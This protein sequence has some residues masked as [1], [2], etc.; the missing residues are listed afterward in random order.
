MDN[1]TTSAALARIRASVAS[2]VVG[3]EQALEQLLVAL[4]CRGHALL[5]DVPGV[6]KTLL[7]R[8]L[9]TVSGASFGR[10]QFTPDVLPSDVTGSSVYNQRTSEFEFRAGPVFTQVLLADEIN[11]ATPRTQAALLEAM[12]ERQV[13]VDG[14]TRP[15]PEPFF[16]VA[17][18]NPIDLE[19]TFP[20]PEAQLDRFLVRVDLGYPS[21]EEEHAILLRYEHANPLDSLVAVSSPA[22]ITAL[23]AARS[24]VVVADEVRG[25]LLAVVRATR[26]DPRV[27]LGA[28]PRAALALHRAVQAKALLS[29]RN[30]AIPDDVKALAEPVLAHRLVLSAQA[31]VRGTTQAEVVGAVL[32]ALAVPVEDVDPMAPAAR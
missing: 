7:A 28:S 9:A 5:E 15:L 17:T 19:G 24:D 14:E 8:S 31:R 20:L 12:E 11:R 3:K 13:T 23:Q 10:I 4:L 2:V 6:G 25:Y 21:L 22:E 32:D 1:S 26:E 29:G 16:V 27:Q 18:Q 30:Y